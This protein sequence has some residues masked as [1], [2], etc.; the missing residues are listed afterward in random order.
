MD[1]ST[2][3]RKELQAL[4]KQNGIKANL[5]NAEI[6]LRLQELPSSHAQ[7]EKPLEEAAPE[8]A[9]APHAAEQEAVDATKLQTTP[10]RK[11]G[12]SAAKKDI[13]KT[14]S[15]QAPSGTDTSGEGA[16]PE[17]A[18]VVPSSTRST[19]NRRS[20]SWKKRETEE[21]HEEATIQ[22]LTKSVDRYAVKRARID[23]G[24]KIPKKHERVYGSV[25]KRTAPLHSRKPVNAVE[26]PPCPLPKDKPVKEFTFQVAGAPQ[27]PVAL[28]TG[29]AEKKK[30]DLAES[31]K[32]PLS[33]KPHT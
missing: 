33:Y 23:E 28:A 10:A 25:K 31:L 14:D 32:K 8:S 22:D 30:F 16:V 12:K 26:Q 21:S 6:I 20:N 29:A 4:A 7:E 18:E 17:E 19:P 2:L 1:Y 24:S 27:F 9:N 13:Q 5:K 11:T 3:S 15:A